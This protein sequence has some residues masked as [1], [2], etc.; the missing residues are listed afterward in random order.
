MGELGDDVTLLR[1]KRPSAASEISL[2]FFR[3]PAGHFIS[4]VSF[5]MRGNRSFLS[6][7]FGTDLRHLVPDRRVQ[8]TSVGSVSPNGKGDGGMEVVE[9]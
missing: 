9:G 3:P 8:D 2:E 5:V 6:G 4:A 1:R 7:G